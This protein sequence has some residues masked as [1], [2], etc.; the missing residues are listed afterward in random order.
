M[1]QVMFEYSELKTDADD[2]KTMEGDALL[3]L[4]EHA[5]LSHAV[6]EKDLIKTELFRRLQYYGT[7]GT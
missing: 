1:G 4:L 5:I 2:L 6:E 3:T 7:Y